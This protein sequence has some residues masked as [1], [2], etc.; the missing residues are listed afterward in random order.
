M[1]WKALVVFMSLAAGS[2][3]A[4]AGEKLMQID[5]REQR[6][7]A[8]EKKIDFDR[9]VLNHVASEKII[10]DWRSA[11]VPDH[12]DGWKKVDED[13]V[14]LEGRRPREIWEWAYRKNAQAVGI[15]ITVHKSGNLEALLEIGRLANR[16]SAAEP[17]YIKGPTN[18]GTISAAR[19]NG[20]VLYWAYRDLSFKVD[21][22]DQEL[23]LKTA[24]WLNSI[25]E[26]HRKPR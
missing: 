4:F 14:A 17:P 8:F 12:L 11:G 13:Y 5:P 25:A 7:K 15:E 26:V 21:S 19:P 6:M 18:L 23:A 2:P 16:S 9:A 20:L 1:I 10:F 3:G 24:Y 22:T